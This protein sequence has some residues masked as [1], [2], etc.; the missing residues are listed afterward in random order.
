K[1]AWVRRSSTIWSQ[2]CIFDSGDAAHGLDESLPSGALGGQD[3]A[4]GGREFVE[5]AAARC[6]PFHP[7]SRNPSTGFEAIEQGIEGRHLELERP[8]GS[9]LDQFGD[10]VPVA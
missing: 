7:G 6:G 4:P 1:P 10:L 9:R 8:A 2:S 3:L 5:A